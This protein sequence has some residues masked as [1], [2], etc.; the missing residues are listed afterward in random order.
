MAPM[1]RKFTPKEHSK[2][3]A[4][5]FTANDLP[6]L[7]FTTTAAEDVSKISQWQLLLCLAI[8][9]IILFV[10]VV[11][12]VVIPNPTEWQQLIFRGL[13]SIGLA[14]ICA[15]I[16]G[17]I[18]VKA[19]AHYLEIAAGGAIAVFVVTWFTNPPKVAAQPTQNVAADQSVNKIQA[20][21][22]V[23]INESKIF[24]SGNKNPTLQPQQAR[25]LELLSGYQI[26]FGAS[27]LIISRTDGM[28]Y[29]D[30]LPDRGKGVSLIKEIYGSLSER[31]AGQ[32]EVLVENMPT[33]YVR[34]FSETRM[35]NPFVVSITKAGSSYL[36]ELRKSNANESAKNNVSI[37]NEDTNKSYSKA[38]DG[39]RIVGIS[40]KNVTLET[41]HGSL[42]FHSG[43]KFVA[44]NGLTLVIKIEF[45]RQRVDFYEGHRIVGQL[46]L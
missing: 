16:P 37:R 33:E 7:G 10:V 32:F 20:G 40:S 3:L 2:E 14:A 11:L 27:K 28:I 5:K 22:D 19:R 43:E 4:Q 39:V 6:T 8:G 38:L 13:F 24:H 44:D 25:F 29:F 35:D 18:N 9:V 26:K 36:M 34:F 21:R 31:N 46:G 41:S 12:A 1:R 45:E 42:T 15:P 30:E 17:F 23:T